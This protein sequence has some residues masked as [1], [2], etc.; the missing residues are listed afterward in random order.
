M[1]DIPYHVLR[2]RLKSLNVN[3]AVGVDTQWLEL[4][5]IISAV[6]ERYKARRYGN[7]D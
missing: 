4:G 1:Y 5:H 2:G 3:N 7:E 6:Q